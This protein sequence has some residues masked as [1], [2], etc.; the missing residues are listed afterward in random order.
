MATTPKN[1]MGGDNVVTPL[2]GEAPV[3]PVM[4]DYITGEWA[5]QYIAAASDDVKNRFTKMQ[6]FTGITIPNTPIPLRTLQLELFMAA[7]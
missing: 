6:A 2:V 3:V 7:I 5:T 1:M 4:P